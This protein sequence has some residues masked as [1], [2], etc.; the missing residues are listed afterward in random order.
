MPGTGAK[1]PSQQIRAVGM[2]APIKSAIQLS[3][4]KS[5]KTVRVVLELN[6][7]FATQAMAEELMELAEENIFVTIKK[8]DPAKHDKL[9]YEAHQ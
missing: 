4:S 3:G 8:Y 5:N 7:E 6:P 1:L 9:I 2:I